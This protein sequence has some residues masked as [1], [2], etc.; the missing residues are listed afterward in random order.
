[1]GNSGD[2]S[3]RHQLENW[4]SDEDPVLR[5]AAAWA[6]ARLMAS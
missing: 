5:K 1:M 4:C 6:I 2:Q 3:F